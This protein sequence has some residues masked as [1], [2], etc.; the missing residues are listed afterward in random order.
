[1][2]CVAV[3]RTVLFHYMW[4][5]NATGQNPPLRVGEKSVPFGC[6][7]NKSS[8]RN[9]CLQPLFTSVLHKTSPRPLRPKLP[10]PSTPGREIP[11]CRKPKRMCFEIPQQSG[12]VLSPFLPSLRFWVFP[13]PLDE[14]V[15]AKKSTNFIN[16]HRV[17][18]FACHRVSENA[19]YQTKPVEYN[20][21]GVMDAFYEHIMQKSEIISCILPNGQ[22]MTPL[23]AIQQTD[24]DDTTTCWVWE[25]G[26]GFTKYNHKVRHHDHVSGQYLFA[27]CNNCNLTL[28]MPNRKRKVM[29]GHV[30]NKK[31]KFEDTNFFPFSHCP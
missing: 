24:Y 4:A 21:P 17:C 30:Q 22:D 18:G 3:M 20:G 11:Q 15:D 28:K 9:L 26:E 1:M 7:Q 27:A 16:E 14:K 2:I 19:E 6:W 23:T 25:C 13:H 8:W 31:P 5:K 29:Q 12:P 10:T